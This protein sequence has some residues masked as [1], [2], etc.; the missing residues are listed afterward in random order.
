M[1]HIDVDLPLWLQLLAAGG[2]GLLVLRMLPRMNWAQLFVPGRLQQFLAVA[3][4]LLLIWSM[5]AESIEGL[6][7]HFLGV[8]TIT[9]VFGG[10]LAIVMVAMVVVVLAVVGTIE[11][12]QVPLIILLT[13]VLPVLVT[14]RLLQLSERRLPAHLFVYL[15]VVGFFGGGLSV[16]V[17]MGAHALVY[18]LFT[19]VSWTMI[20]RDY[21]RYM[22]LMM[23]PEAVLNGMLMTGLVVFRPE[24]VATYSDARYVDG[25]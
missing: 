5:R 7:M 24:W 2:L 9:L 1:A 13:G 21:V 18:G 25:H 16:L 3:L 22:P 12:L 17:V 10:Q 6:A 23:L 14:V 11:L 8:V 4:V 15:Y 20:V 19:E